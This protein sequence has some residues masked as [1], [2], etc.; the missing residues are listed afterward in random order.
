MANI[1]SQKKRN[2]TNAKRAERNKAVR[3]ELKTRVKVAV[4]ASGTDDSAEALRLAVKRLDMAAA[5]G[6]IHPNQAARRK[7]RLMRRLNAG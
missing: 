6:I 7:S 5:K 3:S 4:K 1:K 2:L